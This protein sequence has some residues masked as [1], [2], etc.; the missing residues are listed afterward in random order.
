[1]KKYL[2]PDIPP[3]DIDQT[4]C[5]LRKIS[6]S[7]QMYLSQKVSPPYEWQN[8][9]TREMN[10]DLTSFGLQMVRL[11]WWKKGLFDLKQ[12]MDKSWFNKFVTHYLVLLLILR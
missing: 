5:I 6:L 11:W 3:S 9:K 8:W 4:D 1:M 12:Y 2:G 10:M 7:E